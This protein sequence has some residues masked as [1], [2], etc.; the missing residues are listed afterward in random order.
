LLNKAEQAGGFTLLEILVVIVL[1]ALMIGLVVGA[2]P[3]ESPAASLESAA[4]G[5]AGALRLA[6][7]EAIAHDRPVAVTLDPM[8]RTLRVGRGPAA[9]LAAGVAVMTKAADE[10]PHIVF[11]P[12]GTASGGPII[13]AAGRL[14]REIGI[15]WLTGE[16]TEGQAVERDAGTASP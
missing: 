6:R 5:V 4:D 7:G 15:N 16:V 14:R 12:D 1:L 10:T 11:A 2:G 9:R 13:L 8:A 3:A